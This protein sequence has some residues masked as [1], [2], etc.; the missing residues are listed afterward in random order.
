MKTDARVRYTRERIAQAFYGIL[1]DKPLTKVTV[2]E[3]CERAEINRATFYHHYMD[4][5]DLLEKLEEEILE[6]LRQNIRRVMAS[7]ERDVTERF[8]EKMYQSRK[9]ERSAPI[10]RIFAE[11]PAFPARLVEVFYQESA[12]KMDKRLS[13]LTQEEREMVYRFMISGSGGVLNQWIKGE[14]DVTAAQV[15]DTLFCMSKGLIDAVLP[16][17]REA[18]WKERDTDV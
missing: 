2:R 11:D 5:L 17:R 7:G 9:D 14:I 1:R 10:S 8:L 16:K 15:T 12:M 4:P 18:V 3:I 6:N 13:S